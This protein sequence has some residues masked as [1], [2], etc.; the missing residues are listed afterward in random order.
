MLNIALVEEMRPRAINFLSVIDLRKEGKAI[1]SVNVMTSVPE[2]T[3]HIVFRGTKPPDEDDFDMPRKAQKAVDIVAEHNKISQQNAT[4]FFG[5]FGIKPHAGKVSVLN[6][7]INDGKD[8]QLILV[9]KQK[10]VFNGYSAPLRGVTVGAFSPPLDRVPPYYRQ[11]ADEV[12]AWFEVG[13]FKPMPEAG[14]KKL[15]LAS[16]GKLL[17][18]TLATCRTSF[19]FARD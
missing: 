7:E 3:I 8:V 18:E 11:R 16:T 19:L 17:V 1:G 5:K 14:M 9:L 10:G 4:V 2:S 13:V 6:Q 15:T 12:S